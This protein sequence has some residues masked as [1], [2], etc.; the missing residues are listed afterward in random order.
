MN[1]AIK[2]FLNNSWTKIESVL[3]KKGFDTI[4]LDNERSLRK[5]IYDNIPDTSIVALGSSLCSKT[6]KIRD[7]LLEKGNRIL[8]FWNGAES[9][10]L[11][12]FEDIPKPDYFLTTADMIT[13]NGEVVNSEYTDKTLNDNYFP[14][15]IIA[16]ANYK[17]IDDGSKTHKSTES[18]PVVIERKPKQ[19][20]VTVA[21]IPAE[22]AS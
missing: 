16:F 18:T 21:I 20:A 8:Y 1:S 7:I 19:T 2:Q 17:N 15:N 11:D 12:T 9:R 5:F 13:Q 6:I 3:N 4:V 22:I 14:R 10:H